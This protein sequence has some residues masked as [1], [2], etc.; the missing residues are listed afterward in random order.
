MGGRMALP[1]SLIILAVIALVLHILFGYLIPPGGAFSQ[2][3][4]RSFVA[5]VVIVIVLLL[6]FV[7][8]VRVG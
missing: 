8:P 1:V 3:V 2:P 6:W 7:L 5:V 4:Q